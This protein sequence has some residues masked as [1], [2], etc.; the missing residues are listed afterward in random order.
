[1]RPPSPGRFAPG[2]PG[3]SNDTA[4][5]MGVTWPCSFVSLLGCGVDDMAC[6]P[7]A[8]FLVA[9]E[10]SSS[11]R[12]CLYANDGGV[13]VGMLK[14]AE[15]PQLKVPV[16]LCGLA[17]PSVFVALARVRCGAGLPPARKLLLAPASSTACSP[18]SLYSRMGPVDCGGDVVSS[19][20]SLPLA[21]ELR[22]AVAVLQRALSV[23]HSSAAASAIESWA[24]DEAGVAAARERFWSS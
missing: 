23:P 16:L 1:M 21:L 24:L 4:E 7:W 10:V 12:W 14:H 20:L 13:T 19:K 8:A 5:P 17:F 6:F 9:S 22:P 3:E 11:S 2:P 15:S 18:R